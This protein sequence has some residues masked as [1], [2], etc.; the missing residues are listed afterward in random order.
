MGKNARLHKDLLFPG[1][2]LYKTIIVPK[3][4]TGYNCAKSIEE[5]EA[6][7]KFSKS[8]YIQDTIR[9]SRIDV[10]V[11][12]KSFIKYIYDDCGEP[13]ETPS[14]MFYPIGYVTGWSAYNVEFTTSEKDVSTI[15]GF[16]SRTLNIVNYDL[17]DFIKDYTELVNKRGEA[18]TK[19]GGLCLV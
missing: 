17:T 2:I 18:C 14:E 9:H 7:T 11:R 6:L 15:T 10:F 19:I 3:M 13:K 5:R 4:I 12:D 1:P 16:D 8:D